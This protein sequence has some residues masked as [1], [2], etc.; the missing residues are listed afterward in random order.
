MRWLVDEASL[1]FV[2]VKE[3]TRGLAALLDWPLWLATSLLATGFMDGQ[4]SAAA[5]LVPPLPWLAVVGL[6]ALARRHAPAAGGW[7]RWPA[8]CFLYL[9]WFGQWASAMTD[10]GLDRGGGAARRRA[11]G[12]CSASRP[13]A[14]RWFERALTPAARPDADRADLRLP[15]AGPV[16]LRLRPGGGDDRHHRLR[17]AAHGAG[18]GPGPARRAGGDRRVRP[19]GRLHRRASSPGACW[20]PS[21]RPMLMVGVN[22]VIMLSLNMVIIASMIGAG[23]LG[24][25]VLTAL[26]RLDIGAG[27]EAGMAIVVLA[28]ALD[29]VSQAMAARGRDSPG[30][31]SSALPR[32]PP[33]SLVARRPGCGGLAWPGARALAGGMDP[34]DRALVGRAGGVDQRPLFR[35]AGGRQERGRPEPHGAGQALPARPALAVGDPAHRPRRAAPRR[36]SLGRDLHRP[37]AVRPGHGAVGERDA[38]R[39]SDRGLGP[40]R[41]ADRHPA[42]A[43]PAPPGRGCGAWSRRPST[44]CRP[45]PPSSI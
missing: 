27:L 34:V 3:L 40:D 2:T 6:A 14:I 22:Q 18:D 12:C 42:R 33:P 24:Y 31:T 20:C 7:P 36:P 37:A 44:R 19:D 15:G 43:S 16:L 25:D 26:R 45:C 17:H 29:R 5:Q 32:S 9:A 8:R 21:A 13:T 4:G 1:G 28:I 41:R 35:Y 38:D 30:R 23:G 11:A 39:L 10:A